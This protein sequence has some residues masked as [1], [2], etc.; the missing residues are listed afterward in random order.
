MEACDLFKL[1]VELWSVYSIFRIFIV[2]W[3]V[4]W[5]NICFLIGYAITRGLVDSF[6]LILIRYS[7]NSNLF[8]A[9]SL[10]LSAIAE[11]HN[12]NHMCICCHHSAAPALGKSCSAWLDGLTVCCVVS[13]CGLLL[14]SS[15]SSCSCLI[16]GPA[17]FLYLSCKALAM[18]LLACLPVWQALYA[19]RI[20]RTTGPD[21]DF[22]QILLFFF[23]TDRRSCYLPLPFK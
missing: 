23:F 5:L 4:V 16:A 10:F 22:L 17:T 11:V 20:C 21:A 7:C 3:F 8:F 13:I 12:V 19:C 15:F 2:L 9:S 14:P 6:K 1:I 18:V